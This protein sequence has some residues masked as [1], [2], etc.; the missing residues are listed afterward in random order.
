MQLNTLWCHQGRDTPVRLVAITF[1]LYAFMALVSLIFPQSV[2]VIIA[3]VIA[4]VVL[5]LGVVRRL[6]DAGK[7]MF[8]V[9][10]G[11]LP[12]WLYVSACF[13]V[14][15]IGFIIGAGLIGIAA[16]VFMSFFP[17]AQRNQSKVHYISGYSGLKQRAAVV[18]GSV[19]GRQEPNMSGKPP[20][21]LHDD[22]AVNF[23]ANVDIKPVSKVIEPSIS[24]TTERSAAA[25]HTASTS[26]FAYN[27][28][29]ANDED[30]DLLV[31][32]IDEEEQSPSLFNRLRQAE[33][34]NPDHRYTVDSEALASGSM[35]EL[36]KHWLNL[37]KPHHRA[38]SWGF[39]ILGVLIVSSL[40]VW[41]LVALTTSVSQDETVET[42]NQE[43]KAS[44]PITSDRVMVKLPDGFWVALE[45]NIL[46]IRWLGEEGDA[47]EVWQLSSATGDKSCAEVVFNGGSR[48]RP[49]RVDLMQDGSTEARFSPL[50]LKAILSDIAM[51]GSFKLCGYDFDLKGSQAALMQH[52]K[53]AEKME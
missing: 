35:T 33:I 45:D 17:Q 37:A 15:P 40:I 14:I 36:V 50:D 49:M 12:F 9:L 31:D 42:E 16:C 23:G 2:L 47:R 38:I 18:L 53:I 10:L 13:Y 26:E 5:G 51:R 30:N 28:A 4:S 6:R 3:G 43:T 46:V 1:A 34:F 32:E 19:A 8:F 48:Y 7:P 27:R 24:A 41:G 21:V 11:I 44:V 22:V 20:S 25:K 39:K 52:Q 29:Q